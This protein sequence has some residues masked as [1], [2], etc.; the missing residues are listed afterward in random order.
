MS[1]PP[2]CAVAAAALTL[3][4]FVYRYGGVILAIVGFVVVVTLFILGLG[5]FVAAMSLTAYALGIVVVA[6]WPILSGIGVT[7]YEWNSLRWWAFLATL[8]GAAV[9][10]IWWQN[11]AFARRQT[12]RMWIS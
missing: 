3:V 10:V 11:S 4:I 6:L 5:G 9:Q 2:L 7:L 12:G 8:F 1:L